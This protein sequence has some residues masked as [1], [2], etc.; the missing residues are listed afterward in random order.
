MIAELKIKDMKKLFLLVFI[1]ASSLVSAQKYFTK[2]GFTEFKASVE[3][4]EPVAAKNNS[5]TAILNTSNG[6]FAALIFV[7]AFQFKVALMQE[8]FNENYMDSDQFPKATFKGN[9]IDFSFSDIT[10]KE[11][12]FKIKGELKVHGKAK[13][14]ETNVFIKRVKN[15]IEF[16]GNFKAKPQDFDI[17]IPRIVRDK[18]AKEV[19]VNFNYELKEKK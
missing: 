11:K 5:T 8:H 17:K 6:Q 12:E 19:N 13:L 7:K 4:F 10:E 1:L 15:V 2:T 16:K 3:A 18:I 14:I 9:I